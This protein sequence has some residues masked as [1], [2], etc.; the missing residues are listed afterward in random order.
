MVVSSAARYG[1]RISLLLTLL[2][3]MGFGSMN[4]YCTEPL[5][6]IR[7]SLPVGVGDWKALEGEDRL[8]DQESIFEYIDGAGEVYRA[9]HMR[10]CWARRYEGPQGSAMILDLFDMGTAGDA[11]GVFT[12]DLDGEPVDVG[13]EGLYRAGWLRFWKGRFFVSIVFDEGQGTAPRQTASRLAEMVSDRI[14][15]T[16]RKP[17][18][19][20]RLPSVGLLTRTIRYL[21]DPVILNT[22]YY[23]S[24]E[25]ILGLEP[26]TE[27][28]LA[29]YRRGSQGAM[30]LI[31]SYPS[32]GKAGEAGQSVLRHYLPDAEKA[33]ARLENGRWS[34]V[35]ARGRVVAFVLEAGTLELARDLV[36]ETLGSAGGE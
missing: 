7:A 33:A 17:A 31:V 36:S 5:D 20:S 26:L 6:S 9:Y 24:G 29:E 19:L 10:K 2:I 3:G 28:V 27:A 4:A 22:H 12:H 18:L 30:L 14:L 23:L 8:Y 25:N 34:A 16:G 11:Y 15:E 1:S 21:H 35:G 32:E 13:Q